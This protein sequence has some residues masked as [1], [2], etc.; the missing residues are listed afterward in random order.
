[1]SVVLNGDLLAYKHDMKE[2]DV[3]ECG[4]RVCIPGVPMWLSWDVHEIGSPELEFGVCTQ[5]P[6]LE[7]G[8]LECGVYARCRNVPLGHHN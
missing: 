7:P 4:L 2:A 5:S 8:I 6:D 3:K 1:M